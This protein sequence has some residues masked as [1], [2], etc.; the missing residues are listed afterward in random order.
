MSSTRNTLEQI[1]ANVQESVGNRRQERRPQLSPVAS[2]KDIGRKPLRSFGQIQVEQVIPDPNQPRRE[3][4]EESIARLA[5]SLKSEGQMFPIRVRWSDPDQR[6]VIIS[7]ERRWRATKA[8]GLTTIDCYFHDAELAPAEL[9]EQQLIENLL[10]EDIRPMDQA[11]AFSALMELNGWNGKE[12]A[13]ALHITPSTVSRS[14]SL[15]D[16][17]AAIQQQVE[18]GKIAARSAYEITKLPT[19]DA[20]QDIADRA[21]NGLSHAETTKAVRQRRGKKSEHKS[22][23]TTVTIPAENGWNVVISAAKWGSYYEVLEALQ[24]AVE[25]VQIRIDNDIKLCY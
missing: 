23:A 10:R 18:D 13:A 4:S 21:A 3:F 16:L 14:L 7:G 20:Q 11:R 6:W 25:D 8:A 24:Q 17:P 5:E 1:G 19:K 15:L 2:P 12:L 9:L 22:Q